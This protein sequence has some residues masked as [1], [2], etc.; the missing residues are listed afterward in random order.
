M[1]ENFNSNES[2]LTKKLYENMIL[3]GRF[4]NSRIISDLSER[5]N[6]YGERRQIEALLKAETASTIVS[7]V[8]NGDEEVAKGIAIGIELSKPNFGKIG[9][10]FLVKNVPGYTKSTLGVAL[11]KALLSGLSGERI[12]KIIQGVEDFLEGRTDV[13]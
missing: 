6:I 13:S 8:P 3:N 5:F 9:E 4:T 10:D 12:D 1:N 11:T 2:D 7:L